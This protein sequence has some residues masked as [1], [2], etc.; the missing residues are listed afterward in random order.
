M[1]IDVNHEQLARKKETEFL[2]KKI[3]EYATHV[4]HLEV[5]NV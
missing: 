5:T 2:S 1:S 4:R 3:S